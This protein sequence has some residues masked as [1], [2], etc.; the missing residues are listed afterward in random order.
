MMADGGTV[1][2][3]TRLPVPDV[4]DWS[5]DGA[6]PIG[7]EFIIMDCVPG[8]Q[9][10]VAWPDMSGVQQLECIRSMYESLKEVVDLSFPAYGSIYFNGRVEAEAARDLDERFVIGPHCNA[11]YYWEAGVRPGGGGLCGRGNRGPCEFHPFAGTKMDADLPGDDFDAFCDGLVDAGLSRLPGPEL[12]V[13]KRPSYHGS[14]QD[15]IELLG[16]ARRLLHAMA[17]DPRIQQSTTPTLFHPDLHKRN[18]FV[19][20]KDPTLITGFIDWQSASIEPAFW[21]AD[22]VPD[23]ATP[24]A[25]I[26][27]QSQSQSQALEKRAHIEHLCYQ[28]FDAL[29]TL[30]L[31]RIGHPRSLDANLFRPFRYT[32]NTW[33]HGAVSL[34]HD[35]IQTARQWTAMGF[36]GGCPYAVPS[37]PNLDAHLAEY[38]F[39]KDVVKLRTLVF[40]RLNVP[41]DGWVANEAWEATKQVHGELFE[42]FLRTV[43][44]ADEGPIRTEEDARMVWP[45]DV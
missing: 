14:V 38:E 1:R 4:I 23:F 39:F 36:V 16:H 26:E 32:H 27:S 24:S 8:V 3:K 35:L 41:A 6:N 44:A 31:P 5:D 7:S 22:A 17:T 43:R 25:Q 30:Q 19:S 11:R 21:Y 28:A 40:E 18:I 33:V 37:E 20:A 13:R 34:R 45:F 12:P 42:E 2:S 10:H 9:L 29:T 15:H